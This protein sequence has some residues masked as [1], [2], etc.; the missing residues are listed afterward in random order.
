MMKEHRAGG[1]DAWDLDAAIVE[2]KG[3]F[4]TFKDVSHPRWCR[5]IRQ[6]RVRP[7]RRPSLAM[8]WMMRGRLQVRRLRRREAMNSDVQACTP[9]CIGAYPFAFCY[10]C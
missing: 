4:G 8:T 9:I 7:M 6:P 5:V 2:Y 1:T 10:F 3:L